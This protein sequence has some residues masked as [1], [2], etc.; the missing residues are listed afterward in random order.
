MSMLDEY[1]AQIVRK[2]PDPPRAVSIRA[3]LAHVYRTNEAR[4]MVGLGLV[5]GLPVTIVAAFIAEGEPW[6]RVV[7]LA[8]V[9]PTTVMLLGT[10]AFASWR[11]ARALASGIRVQGEI[12]RANW[13]DPGTRVPTIAASASGMTRGTRRVHHP[14]GQFSESFESDSAWS[15]ALKPGTQVTL[16]AHPTERRVFFDLGPTEDGVADE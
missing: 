7:L 13:Q 2:L 10:P 11:L 1:A 6:L 12:V 9:V 15:A 3:V 8:I 16:L 4:W 14:A 5:L